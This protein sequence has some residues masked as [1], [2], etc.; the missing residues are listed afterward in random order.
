M[1][2]NYTSEVPVSRSIAI[3]QDLLVKAGSRNVNFQ[4]SATG[5]LMGVIFELRVNEQPVAIMV[6]AK[7]KEVETVFVNGK[8]GQN[9]QWHDR[10]RE[11][12]GR[13]AWKTLAEWIQINIDLINLNQ[14]KPLEVFLP[15]VY[16]PRTKKTYFESLEKNN[17]K[18]LALNEDAKC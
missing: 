15:Y 4:Y 16:D 5:E 18:A 3:I 6:P 8:K 10:R 11:Q 9:K 13:T 14:V 12:A 2:R 1:L 17:F 7:I